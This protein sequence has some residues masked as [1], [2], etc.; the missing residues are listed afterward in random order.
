MVGW[1]GI[2]NFAG[3]IFLPGSENLTR[4]DFDDSKNL[5][6]HSVTTED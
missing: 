4:S 1:W 6:Q 5:K 3:E 2:V